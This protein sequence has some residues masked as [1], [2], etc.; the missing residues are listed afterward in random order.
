MENAFDFSRLFESVV[1]IFELMYYGGVQLFTFF[2]APFSETIGTDP[3][4][5]EFLGDWI[6]Y[7]PFELMFGF[8]MVFVLTMMFVKLF[9]PI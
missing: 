6:S 1:R 3:E 5:A 9:I 7:T 4:I 8:G 2:S